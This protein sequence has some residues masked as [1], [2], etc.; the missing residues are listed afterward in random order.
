[1]FEANPTIRRISDERIASGSLTYNQVINRT[2]VLLLLTSV[3]FALT[4]RGI[5]TEQISPVVGFAGS[6][7]G[8]VLGLILAFT[9]ITNPIMIGAYAICQGAALGTISVFVNARYPGIALQAVGGTMGCFLTVLWLYSMRVLRATPLFTKVIIGSLIGIAVLYG[10]NFIMSLFGVPLGIVTGNSGLSIG[11]SLFIVA[12][13]A[14]SFVIDFAAIEQAVAEG[15]D[16]KYGWRFA[17][18]LIMGLV[19]LY[20]EILR[21]L[22]KMRSRD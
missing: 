9:Q 5:Q 4:W 7:L 20:L 15:I 18:G 14:L 6:I 10:V 1:M 2:G 19:W 22:M 12:I 17:F 3:T 8:F 16:E 13:G 11:L 21:L